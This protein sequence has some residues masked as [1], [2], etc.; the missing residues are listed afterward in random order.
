MTRELIDDL[1]KTPLTFLSFSV[2]AG[3]KESYTLLKGK[4]FFD[5]IQKMVAYAYQKKE[6]L[7]GIFRSSAQAFTLHQKVQQKWIC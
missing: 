4:D 7:V 6:S 5:Y 1:V 2:D 3:T